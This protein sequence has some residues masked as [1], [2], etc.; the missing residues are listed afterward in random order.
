MQDDAWSDTWNA[1]PTG[2]HRITQPIGVALPRR[3]DVLEL[4]DGPG[5][6]HHVDLS[7]P[8]LTLGRGTQASCQVRSALVSREHLRITLCGTE[9]TVTDLDSQ[10][11]VFLNQVRIHSAVLRDGDLLQVGDLVYV[12]RRGVG[13]PSL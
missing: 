7:E 6:P 11:G 4:V 8:Q 12:F 9:V 13:C 5:Q 10:N 3:A 2:F 1:E